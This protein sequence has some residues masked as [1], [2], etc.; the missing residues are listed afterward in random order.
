MFGRAL[1][2]PYFYDK[3]KHR[4]RNMENT[5]VFLNEKHTGPKN[6][7]NIL[8]LPVSVEFQTGIM[9]WSYPIQIHGISCVEGIQTLIIELN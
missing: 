7:S 6:W 2:R 4:K 3:E 5:I 9:I 1:T 8:E